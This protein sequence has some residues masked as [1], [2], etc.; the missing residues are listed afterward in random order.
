MP[1]RGAC[2]A[3]ETAREQRDATVQLRLAP[4][5]A[6]PE[7]SNATLDRLSNG[8]NGNEGGC[9]FP[10]CCR[11]ALGLGWRVEMWGHERSDEQHVDEA[12]RRSGNVGVTKTV[13]TN[14]SDQSDL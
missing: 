10:E 14:D 1:S 12:G 2:D 9:S 8:P 7:L 11:H 13:S 4:L 6:L 3:A 5:A